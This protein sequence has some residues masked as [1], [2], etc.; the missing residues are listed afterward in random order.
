MMCTPSWKR[1]CGSRDCDLD[2]REEGVVPGARTV[3]WISGEQ[4]DLSRWRR[5]AGCSSLR[6]QKGQRHKDLK[7]VR[8]WPFWA[9]GVVLG[10]GVCL[11][12][13]QGRWA[14]VAASWKQHLQP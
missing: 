12:G 14:H 9:G 2:L 5:Q 3:T 10:W 1:W 13:L 6:D 4:G 8:R 11:P 7:H